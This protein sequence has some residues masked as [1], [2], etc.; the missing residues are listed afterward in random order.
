[1]IQRQWNNLKSKASAPS[2]GDYMNPN[3]PAAD[4]GRL[5]SSLNLVTLN[6]NNI[7]DHK[8]VGHPEIRLTYVNNSS[9]M[10][11]HAP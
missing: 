8:V 9:S 1:M 11:E 4:A 7:E 3:C 2:S 5:F 6:L 10:T